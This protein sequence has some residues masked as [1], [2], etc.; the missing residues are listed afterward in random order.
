M[1]GERSIVNI[2]SASPILTM[3]QKNML[4]TRHR[5]PAQEKAKEFPKAQEAKKEN[6]TLPP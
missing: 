2:M 4:K 5:R 6:M 3:S 1:A